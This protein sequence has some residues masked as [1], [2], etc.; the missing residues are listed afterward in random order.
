[1][2]W[3]LWNATVWYI[4][5]ITIIYLFRLNYPVQ[6]DFFQGIQIW[7]KKGIKNSKVFSPSYNDHESGYKYSDAIAEIA[8]SLTRN[9]LLFLIFIYG[10]TLMAHIQCPLLYSSLTFSVLKTFTL[11]Q[12]PTEI[13]INLKRLDSNIL[14]PKVSLLP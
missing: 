7:F 5:T 10:S 4:V 2:L 8:I 11:F 13:I 14:I 6:C 3:K 1:M 12:Q 9:N